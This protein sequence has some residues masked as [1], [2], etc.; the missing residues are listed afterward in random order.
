MNKELKDEIKAFVFEVFDKFD[1]LENENVF[2]LY[3]SQ[4][5]T[6][7]TPDGSFEGIDGFASWYK[8]VKKDL[9]KPAVHIVDGFN[10]KQIKENLFELKFQVDFQ[11]ITKDNEKIAIKVNE[12]WILEKNDSRFSIRLY[13]ISK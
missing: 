5:L 8:E 11:A 10:Y 1:A 13:V 7:I 9:V 3:L 4:D 6:L 2:T 12:C